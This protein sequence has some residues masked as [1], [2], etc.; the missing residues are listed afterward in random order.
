MTADTGLSG[1]RG[2]DDD[3]LVGCDVVVQSYYG[4]PY[5]ARL[6]DRDGARVS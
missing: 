4:S 6:C 1:N 5:G 2:R 3:G